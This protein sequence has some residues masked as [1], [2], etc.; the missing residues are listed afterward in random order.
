MGRWEIKT[1]HE[2]VSQI[3]SS[4]QEEKSCLKVES[5]AG[6]I[7]QWLKILVPFSEDSDSILSTHM[8]INNH[9]Q[10]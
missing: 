8:V 1:G 4:E 6:E 9:M 10:V 5:K 7:A 3:F 2:S